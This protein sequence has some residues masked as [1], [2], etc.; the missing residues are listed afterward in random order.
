MCSIVQDR[1]GVTRTGAALRP[2]WQLTD[3]EVETALGE[4][5]D[6]EA[7]LVARRVELVTEADQRSM[8]DRSRALSTDRWLQDRFRLSHRDAKARVD[9]A[10]LLAGQPAAHAA[11]AAGTV[12]P[13]QAVVVATCLD[14]V[15]QLP[16]VDP[17]EREEA[18]DF[19][20]GQAAGLEPRHLAAAAAHLVERLTRTPSTDTAADAEAVARELAAAE[21]AAQAPE[22]D[23][24]VVKHRPD[25]TIAY[26][27]TFRPTD[28]PVLTAWLKQADKRHPGDDGFD[29]DRPREH[30]R[31][32]HLVTTLRQAGTGTGTGGG[33]TYVHLTVTTTLD[34]LREKVTGAGILDTGGTLS[35]AELRRLACDAGLAPL[36]LGGP[37]QVL[38]Y[39]RT[40]RTF[41]QAPRRALV[42]RDQGCIAPSCDRTPADC[43]AHHQ[44]EWDHGGPTDLANG[45]L[46]CQY[47]HQQVHRQDW[48][49]QLARNG[50]PELIPP[51]SIDPNAD[52]DSTTGSRSPRSPADDGPEPLAGDAR[53]RTLIVRDGPYRRAAHPPGAEVAA[54][55]KGP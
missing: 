14:A 20:I 22:I 51:T 23:T 24:L 10:R 48:T 46:L 49:V 47:H 6:A 50:Y 44:W 2:V 31:G 30:R 52:P 26:R 4:I 13:E 39:G 54:V 41:P 53:F 32:D 40:R 9:Q 11:L 21:A 28:A 45:A 37:S 5:E 29:D 27:G 19:L 42:V 8:K 17:V 38:D 25:G 34:A 18:A 3:D 16:G 7:R 35:A 12:T 55:R 43:D 1:P 33:R 15:D 36:V